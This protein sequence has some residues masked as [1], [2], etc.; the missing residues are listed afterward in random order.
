[1]DV[2]SLDGRVAVTSLWM[3]GAI[4]IAVAFHRYEIATVLAL[5][6]FLTLRYVKEL[7]DE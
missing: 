3:T 5:L 4:G 7:K 6:N 1:M 2:C